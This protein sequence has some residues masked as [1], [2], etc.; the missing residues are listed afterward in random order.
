MTIARRPAVRGAQ[1][2]RDAHRL[3][4]TDQVT[5]RVEVGRIC[6]PMSGHPAAAEH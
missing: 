5:L 2:G 3:K 6:M 4:R 1:D